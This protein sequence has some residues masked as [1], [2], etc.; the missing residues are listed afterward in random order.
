M[1]TVTPGR[2]APLSSVTVPLSCAVACAQAG[3][4]AR[5]PIRTVTPRHLASRAMD[6]PCCVGHRAQPLYSRKIPN[7]KSQS[8]KPKAQRSPKP[9][10]AQ[11]PNPGTTGVWVLSF[12]IWD[13]GFG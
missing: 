9:Q 2:T 10:K 13:L 7:P 3:V 8:P 4:I 6:P 5:N 1:V 12:G 11:N